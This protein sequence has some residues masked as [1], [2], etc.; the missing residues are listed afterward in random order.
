M[1]I[2]LPQNECCLA[3]GDL[4][5]VVAASGWR[6]ECTQ[7]QLWITENGSSEDIFIGPGEHYCIRTSGKVLIEGVT[8]ARL[9][10]Q[11]VRAPNLPI[12]R[13]RTVWESFFPA[14]SRALN[15]TIRPASS[16]G[17]PS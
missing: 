9:R 6:I 7:G 11:R 1:I 10:L 15:Q 14:P 13:L 2:E 8:A 4:L 12:Q 5:K 17:F 3:K 16:A